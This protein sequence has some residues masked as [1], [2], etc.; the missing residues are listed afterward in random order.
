MSGV[1]EFQISKISHEGVPSCRSNMRGKKV[2]VCVWGGGGL[3]VFSR[4][5]IG[6]LSMTHSCNVEGRIPAP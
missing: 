5:H 2:C 6:H 3:S 4:L 1:I